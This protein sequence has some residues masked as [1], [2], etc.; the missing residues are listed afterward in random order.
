MRNFD[1]TAP[2]WLVAVSAG[3]PAGI[4][5][6]GFGVLVEGTSLT[7][8]VIT[9][10]VFALLM[11]AA[12]TAAMHRQRRLL[13]SAVGELP[14]EALIVAARAAERGPVPAD[15][16]LRSTARAIAVR[17]L[18]VLQR[19][20]LRI[21]FYVVIALGTLSAVMSVITGGGWSALLPVVTPI[22]LATLV[23]YQP[24]RLRARIQLLSPDPALPVEGE[25][26]REGVDGGAGAVEG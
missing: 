10:A 8:G 5:A 11:G 22:I 20:A 18:E 17:R 3:V 4:I 7:E 23:F 9:G 19:P 12:I 6:G 21:L 24:R 1:I 15:P 13:R 14:R 16:E 26:S 25:G 2:L